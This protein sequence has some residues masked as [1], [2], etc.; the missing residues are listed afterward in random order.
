MRIFIAAC[1]LCVFAFSAEITSIKYV[2][3]VRMSDLI[4]NEVSGLKIGDTLDAKKVNDA[5]LA[6]FKQDYFDDIYADFDNGVLT[7]YFTEKPGIGSIE[8]VGYGNEQETTE[9]SRLIGI[10]RGDTY[11]LYKEKYAKE[12][13]IHALEEKGLYGSVVEV[14]STRTEDS[15]NLVFTVNKGENIIIRKSFYEGATLSKDDLESL[16]ANR[17]RHSWL[18]WLPWWSSGE[19][20]IQ[21]LEYD[22]LRI[23]DV[24]MRQGYLDAVVSTPLLNANFTNYDATL[25]YKV[26][27]GER[28]ILSGIDIIK[29]DDI[30]NV[31]PIEELQDLISIKE[32][33]YFNIESIRRD[34]E[35]IRS[36]IMDKGYAYARISP[37]LDKDETEHKVKVVYSIDI[38]KKVY[39]NDVIISGN[40]VSADRIVRRDLLIAPG[41]TYS[42][43]SIRR[44]ENA[45]RRSGF[46]DNVNISEIR[47]GEDSMNLLVEV[48]EG[49]T[50]EIMFGLGYGSYDKLMVNASLR[51]RN[52]FGTG[53]TLQLYVSWSRYTQLYSIGLT[54]PRL[55]D[56]QYSGSINVFKSYF[57]NYDYTEDSIGFNV[58][59]GRNITDELSVN[60]TYGLTQSY[61]NDFSS[62]LYEELYR[63][64]FPKKGILKSAITPGIYFDNTDDYY[65]P[66]NGAILQASADFAGVGGDAKF[67]KLSGK[68][69]LYYH[70]KDLTG[71]DLILRYKAQIGA[72]FD[73][74][75]VPITDTYYMGGIGTVR[76]YETYS[77]SP[78]DYACSSTSGE[79][80]NLRIGGNYM[81]T[82]SV[83]VSYGFLESI[84]MRIAAFFDYGMLGKKSFNEIARMSWGLA[85]EWVS[86]IGPLVFVFPFAI[87]PKSGDD[88]SHFEFTM[89][90][91]F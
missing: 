7:F 56:T 64:Y 28:Y 69:G 1:I 27:E 11:D 49:R 68:A 37:D 21:E 23:Q 26:T 81:F 60:L 2:G 77:L 5:I 78:R 47:L 40:S 85:L 48:A 88:V 70:L 72:I 63:Q 32:G 41:D 51:E 42:I 15:I 38:G 90:T 57:Y 19:L 67:I 6:F 34:M 84:N 59:V 36:H 30:D 33:E 29:N 55:F 65:F 24:Y 10:K 73:T 35:A 43:T 22:N 9:I 58:S 71:L 74:G 18:G 4:A 16:S 39:I 17:E 91:R 50:G 54:N 25:I 79:C 89:G 53:N 76:G 62:S 86:P 45:L 46:F 66:K 8:I 61:L 13:I 87:N 3:L 83:E 52:L 82:N 14:S 80:V 31:F 20:K 12:L 75:N 44:S